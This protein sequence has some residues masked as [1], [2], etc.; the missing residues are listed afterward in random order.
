M[1]IPLPQFH[2]INISAELFEDEKESAETASCDKC[3]NTFET[4]QSHKKHIGDNVTLDTMIQ[5]SE[6]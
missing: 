3:A 1:K 4:T 5:H 6:N 2:K